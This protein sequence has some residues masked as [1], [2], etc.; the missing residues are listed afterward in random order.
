ME[1]NE[2]EDILNSRD[3]SRQV[4]ATDI[5]AFGLINWEDS[6]WSAH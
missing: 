5:V 6:P 3:A 2:A 4:E 1:E